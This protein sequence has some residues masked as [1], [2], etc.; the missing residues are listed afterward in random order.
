METVR[1]LQSNSMEDLPEESRP[2]EAY[3]ILLTVELERATVMD[4]P[5]LA[6]CVDLSKAYDTVR[7]DLLEFLLVGSGVPAVV[8][9]PMLDMTRASRRLNVMKAIGDL[10][11]PT[12]G[13]N[14][15]CPAAAF[16]MSLLLEWW[17]RGPKA[18]CPRVKVKCW[19]DDSTAW[20]RGVFEG[21]AAWAGATSGMEDLE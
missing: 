13:I 9:K 17:R 14:P 15:G 21:L 18:R 5:V 16:I 1:W 6:V 11:D 3:G 10:R 20:D 12:A 8:W 4:D 7:H 19:V 2:A